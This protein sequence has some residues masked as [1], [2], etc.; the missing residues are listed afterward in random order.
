MKV[1][2]ILNIGLEVSPTNEYAK[3]GI[4]YPLCW[5]P[6]EVL[7]LLKKY[8]FKIKEFKVAH[9]DSELTLVVYINGYSDEDIHNPLR[10]L[11]S[12]ISPKLYQEAIAVFNQDTQKGILVGKYKEKWGKFNPDFFIF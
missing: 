6:S 1:D 10:M 3:R 9:S 4:T 12:Y 5:L 2:L 11:S 8:G 7:G